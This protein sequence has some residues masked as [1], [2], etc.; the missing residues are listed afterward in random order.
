M[1][2]SAT[3]AA[4]EEHQRY[5][6]LDRLAAARVTPAY[7]THQDKAVELWLTL[8]M[9]AYW[10]RQGAYVELLDGAGIALAP[11][12]PFVARNKPGQIARANANR[13]GSIRVDFRPAA[14][15]A[16]GRPIAEYEIIGSL[17]F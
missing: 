13:P 9:A 15:D 12:A 16:S 4:T 1:A 2:T 6:T 7:S 5:A 17:Q 3:A 8:R 14:I 11:G 10:S